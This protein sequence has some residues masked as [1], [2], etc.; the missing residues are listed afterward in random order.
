M[1]SQN[2][3]TK[4]FKL[5]RLRFV[6]L[7]IDRLN[8]RFHK[9]VTLFQTF[10]TTI[11]GAGAGVFVFWSNKGVDA[12]SAKL[13]I[14]GLL[15]L[16]TL[17]AAF[18]IVFVVTGIMSWFD[19]RNEE[20]RILNDCVESGYRKKPSLG[21]LFRWHEFYLLLLVVATVGIIALF[22]CNCILPL[23]K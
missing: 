19:Y 9:Y 16:L 8:E 4:E 15:G 20:A 2:D 14:E 18:V 12:S 17:L 7:Q 21:N 13:I 11:V 10:A 23:I 3:S 22:S 6:N 1:N 5:E